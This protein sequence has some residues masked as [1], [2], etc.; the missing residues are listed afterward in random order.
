[1][2]IYSCW[3]KSKTLFYN[4]EESSILCR[5]GYFSSVVQDGFLGEDC[6]CIR[7]TDNETKAK[8]PYM[9]VDN[10]E[11]AIHSNEAE[12]VF[13]TTPIYDLSGKKLPKA[14]QKGLYIQNGKKVTVK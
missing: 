4:S 10:S 13:S 12:P 8:Y 14:P 2:N 5:G 1:M 6:E 9:V 11:D 7:N 3:L